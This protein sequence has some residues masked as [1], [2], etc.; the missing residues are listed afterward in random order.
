VDS[1]QASLSVTESGPDTV[2][3]H[4]METIRDLLSKMH[5]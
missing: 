3:D 4:Y 1:A 5:F 2:F